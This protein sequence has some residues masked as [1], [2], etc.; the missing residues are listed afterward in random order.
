MK[1]DGMYYK[2]DARTIDWALVQLL[3]G[4]HRDS[5]ERIERPTAKAE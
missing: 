2:G 3:E 1:R 4:N 5:H